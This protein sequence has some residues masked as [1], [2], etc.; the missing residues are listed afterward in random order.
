MKI[1]ALQAAN[2]KKLTAVE[3]RPDGN[4]VVISGKN[5]AGKTSVL[6]SI[7]WAIEGA[8]HIQA[9]PIR[10]GAKK[11][12]IR[13]DL[14][15][16]IVS[17]TF[18]KGKDDEKTTTSLSVESP[19]GAVFRSPQKI[20]DELLGA[21]SFDPLGFARADAKKQV[22]MVRALVPGFDFAKTDAD[23]AGDYEKRRDVNRSIKDFR[24]QA[25]AIE[26]EE[27][28]A[29][30]DETA[31]VDELEKAGEH[32]SDIETRKANRE[33]LAGNA[34]ALEEKGRYH[35]ER[36]ESLR[37]QIAAVERQAK[38][39]ADAA[40]LIR[41]KLADAAEL[42]APIDTAAIR[43]KIG[44][45]RANNAKWAE[46]DRKRI[47]LEKITALEGTSQAY[48]DAI[49]KRTAAKAKAIA[50]AKLPVPG[51]SFEADGVTLNGVPFEQ[52]SDA[53][54]LRASVAIAAALN[55][56]LRVIR[57]RDGSLLDEDG[58]KLLAEL[59]DAQDMQVWIERVDTSGKVGF[60]IEDGHLAGAGESEGAE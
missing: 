38:E 14:G 1:I 56:K 39:D 15:E 60:V 11:A 19:D 8:S 7:S 4:L 50:E 10:K 5:G 45:A 6:D 53:E 18:S 26:V 9:A 54:Q 21:L 59:A 49:E 32:N 36:L 47:L 51:L 37:E 20:L 35:E 3:I 24:A 33:R 57:I 41:K 48:T 27:G 22:D 52:G 2:V 23:N 42:P 46:A 40:K 13:L 25:D 43:A 12:K 29:V 31:L 44:D 17:R 55:P 28:L 30:I 16:L 58:M 34:H